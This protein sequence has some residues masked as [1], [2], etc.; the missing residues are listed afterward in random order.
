MIRLTN[1]TV[2]VVVAL[3]LQ[4]TF[5]KALAGTNPEELLKGFEAEAKQENKAFAGF[6][7]GAGKAFYGA[8]QTTKKGEKVSCGSC[9][10]AD[11]TKTGKTRAGK[12]I[13]P[14][15]IS[16][17]PKR[18]TDKAKVDKWFKRNCQDVYERVCTPKEKGDFISYMKTAK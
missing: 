5:G 3:G 7:A 9:H 16:A 11:P 17:N 4:M 15:A 14:M 10:T 12:A 8:E 2:A 13:E 18:F 6:D 1:V